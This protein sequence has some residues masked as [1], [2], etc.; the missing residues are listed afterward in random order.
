M[1]YVTH[2]IGPMGNQLG[3]TEPKQT[4]E[5]QETAKACD[6]ENR[7]WKTITSRIEQPNN[8]LHNF[9]NP[10]ELIKKGFARLTYFS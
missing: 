6:H 3:L 1:R 5:P 4:L 2:E 10:I 9:G 8:E 7:K